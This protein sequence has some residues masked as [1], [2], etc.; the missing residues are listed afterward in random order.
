MPGAG[1][2]GSYDP[3]ETSHRALRGI[4]RELERHPA[5]SAVRGF[6]SGAYTR[7]I[8]EI[9]TDRAEIDAETATFT[10]SWFAGETPEAPPEFSFHYS[11]GTSD[12]GWHHHPQDH[13]EEWGHVQERSDE[14]DA[15][16]YEPYTLSSLN[17]TRV[18][19]EV[20]SRWETRVN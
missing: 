19:W 12:V 7:V 1:G 10:V 17:P 5:I 15:Y 6:P 4:Q 11:D 3:G 18:V 16:T 9:A 20:L 14:T 8:G 13:V 2:P